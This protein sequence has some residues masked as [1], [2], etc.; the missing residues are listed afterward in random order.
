MRPR[1]LLLSALLAQLVLLASPVLGADA[2]RVPATDAPSPGCRAGFTCPNAPGR[3]DVTLAGFDGSG[4]TGNEAGFID[5]DELQ[6]ALDCLEGDP[7]PDHVLVGPG[8]PRT[9]TPV[10]GG[11][12]ALDPGVTYRVQRAVRLPAA[13]DNAFI[14]DGQGARLTIRRTSPEPITVLARTAPAGANNCDVELMASWAVMWTIENVVITGDGSE[15]DTGIVIHGTTSLTI[16]NSWFGSLGMGVDLRFCVQANVDQCMFLNNRRHDVFLGD[17]TGECGPTGT[18]FPQCATGAGIFTEGGGSRQLTE[19]GCHGS[20]VRH[21][22]FL[23]NPTQLSSIRVR[24]SRACVVDAPMFDGVR[25]RHAIHHSDYLANDFTVRDMYFETN[26]ERADAVIRFDGGAR[27]LVE[28]FHVVSN[29][30]IVAVDADGNPG[31]V[32]IVRS[33]PWMPKQIRFS[34]GANAWRNEWRFQDVLADDLTQPARWAGGPPPRSMVVDRIT[35]DRVR[36][37][38]SGP[39]ERG[40]KLKEGQIWVDSKTHRLMFCCD[41]EG[42][43]KPASR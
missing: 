2:P 7:D 5:S 37:P 29:V 10:R 13:T 27:L 40:D 25:G 15:G 32:I 28:G 30:P 33:V 24:N 6:C 35:D 22:R 9:K 8:A 43:A 12:V 11:R 18:C 21:C 17:G 3:V 41:P 20:V 39:V 36:L 38:T 34:N 31:A 4:A 14:F 26:V 23:M 19:S 16:R 42:R 1:I